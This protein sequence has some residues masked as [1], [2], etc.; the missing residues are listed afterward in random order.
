MSI[1]AITFDFWMTLFEERNRHERHACRVEAFCKATGAPR[2]E[3]S[4]ALR[5]AHDYFFHI[6]EHEQ[7]TLTPRDAVDMVCDALGIA[8][9]PEEAD[10]MA[11]VF[12]TAIHVFP[13]VPIPGALDAVKAASERVPVGLIS[14]SG[15][16]PGASLRKLL[17]DNGFTPHF[18][19]LT[20]SDEVGVAK[21]QAPMFHRTAAALGVAPSELFHVGDLEPTDIRGVQAVGGV[22]ALFAGANPRFASDTRAEHTFHRWEEFLDLLPG[23]LDR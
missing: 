1:R 6:H 5:A 10:A 19:V 15:M 2:E 4:Q 8:L 23:L 17:D 13:P 18:T 16:S 9:D 12:G 21:P 20:F 14:D 7:R 22:A 11:D 3:T